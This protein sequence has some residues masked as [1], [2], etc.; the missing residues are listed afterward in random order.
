[1]EKDI[2]KN[3][4]FTCELAAEIENVKNIIAEEA[5]CAH[6]SDLHHFSLSQIAPKLVQQKLNSREIAELLKC[7]IYHIAHWYA[8]RKFSTP[9]RKKTYHFGMMIE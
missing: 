8:K 1:M 9:T 7:K 2:I 3:Y 5:M 6:K 4:N